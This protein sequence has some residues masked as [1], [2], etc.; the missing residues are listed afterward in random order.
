MDLSSPVL[1][2]WAF[3]LMV[4][5]SIF[6]AIQA[7]MRVVIYLAWEKE[8][9]KFPAEAKTFGDQL[10]NWFSMMWAARSVLWWEA[11]MTL[12]LVTLVVLK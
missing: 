5:W 12:V 2:N 11:I 8:G 7:G 9:Y 3:A 10:K 4:F 1:E 6:M